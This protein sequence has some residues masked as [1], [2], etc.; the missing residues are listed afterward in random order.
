MK[1]LLCAIISI[2]KYIYIFCREYEVHICQL[3]LNVHS[4]ALS[5]YESSLLWNL[6]Y[7]VCSMAIL[8]QFLGLLAVLIDRYLEILLL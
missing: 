4:Y 8:I 2:I 6:N 5:Y 1:L 3:S 7:W